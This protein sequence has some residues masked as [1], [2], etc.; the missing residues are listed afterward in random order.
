MITAEEA[1]KKYFMN[2]EITAEHNK[3]D[4]VMPA[5]EQQIIKAATSGEKGV[6]IFVYA[7]DGKIFVDTPEFQQAEPAAF[8]FYFFCKRKKTQRISDEAIDYLKSL[9]KS[10][11]YKIDW[12]WTCGG[13]WFPDRYFPYRDGKLGHIFTILW[14]Y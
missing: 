1:R 5:I 12:I 2:D 6:D 13:D 8:P 3:I 7:D 11:G 14:I 4:S 9:L 10:N